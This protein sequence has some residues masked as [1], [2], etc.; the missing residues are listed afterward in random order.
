MLVDIGAKLALVAP[1]W[2]LVASKH[3]LPIFLQNS[4]EKYSLRIKQWI[5]QESNIYCTTQYQPKK[6]STVCDTIVHGTFEC[7]IFSSKLPKTEAS[8]AAIFRCTSIS[9]EGGFFV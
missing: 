2:L 9:E 3:W 1:W 5:A 6:C 7:K 4:T 8:V